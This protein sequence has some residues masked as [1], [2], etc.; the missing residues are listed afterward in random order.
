MPVTLQQRPVLK[1]PQ[2]PRPP[3]RK[4]LLVRLLWPLFLTAL[5]AA[6]IITLAVTRKPQADPGEPQTS[7]ETKTAAEQELPDWIIAAYIPVDGASRR[8]EKLEGLTGIVIHYVGNPGT[9]AMQNRNWF[10]NADSDVS[11]HFVVGLEGEIVLCVPLDEKASASNQANT[12]TISV[13][14]CH[15][16]ETGKFTE[17]SEAALVKLLTYLCRRFDLSPDSVIRHYDVTGK[18]CPKYYVEHEE[19][20]LAMKERVREALS[21]EETA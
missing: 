19:A 20:Y 3:R 1:A 15:P 5:L 14:V 17:E 8:G 7:A 10:A 2:A 13:E 18:I 12:D 4:P 9:T 6:L 11:S 16:D 21:R